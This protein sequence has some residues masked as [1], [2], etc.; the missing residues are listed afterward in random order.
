[1]EIDTQEGEDKKLKKREVGSRPKSSYD[2]TIN[3]V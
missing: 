1:M 3:V 2:P